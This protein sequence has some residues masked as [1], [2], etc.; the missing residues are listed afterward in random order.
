LKRSLN[1]NALLSASRQKQIVKK[2]FEI[3]SK[4]SITF[5]H[6][7]L[8]SLYDSCAVTELMYDHCYNLSSFHCH[9]NGCHSGAVLTDDV[10]FIFPMYQL[11]NMT[12]KLD[13]RHHVSKNCTRKFGDNSVKLYTD[14]SFF[15]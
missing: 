12:V 7:V 15:F 6:R 3:A 5:L 11:R 1:R 2:F 10:K 8:I 4:V 14:L 9:V 13:H